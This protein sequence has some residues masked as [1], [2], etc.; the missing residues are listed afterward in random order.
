MEYPWLTEPLSCARQDPKAN[1]KHQ[2]ALGQHLDGNKL[3][4]AMVQRF[5]LRL[6]EGR[7]IVQLFEKHVRAE[8]GEDSPSSTAAGVASGLACGQQHERR[9]GAAGQGRRSYCAVHT[10]SLARQLSAG[11]GRRASRLPLPFGRSAT[12]LVD[13]EEDWGASGTLVMRL[14]DWLRFQREEQG[15]RDEDAA[16]KEF[17]SV[18]RRAVLREGS[19]RVRG[20]SSEAQGLQ[21]GDAL[22]EGEELVLYPLD[23]QQLMLSPS[24]SAV[25]PNLSAPKEGNVAAAQA[26]ALNSA[27]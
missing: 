5:M 17:L 12:S 22:G 3:N 24:N 8:G 7:A 4:M 15:R 19:N 2:R 6:L 23:F 9:V 1:A 27:Q 21:A 16:T 18:A 14:S 25:C 26:H 20:I 13:L 11:W 10:N